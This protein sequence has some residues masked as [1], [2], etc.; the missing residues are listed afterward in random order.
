MQG[1][2]ALVRHDRLTLLL[3]EY[4]GSVESRSSLGR[5]LIPH[6]YIY[7]DYVRGGRERGE[8]VV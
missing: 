7:V 8:W 6:V 3:T 4:F 1:V 2:P 5:F